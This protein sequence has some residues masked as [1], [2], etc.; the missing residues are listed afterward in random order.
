MINENDSN[1][2]LYM[3][4]ETI[5][6]K[7]SDDA[8]NLRLKFGNIKHFNQYHFEYLDNPIIFK[9]NQCVRLKNM[10]HAIK[11]LNIQ[12][13]DSE[14]LSKIIRRLHAGMRVRKNDTILTRSNAVFL[15]YGGESL[16]PSCLDGKEFLIEIEIE[17]YKT[18]DSGFPTPIWSLVIAHQSCDFL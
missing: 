8:N 18:N 3:P 17:G 11:V 12:N 13:E 16:D 2:K 15:G 5:N 1:E 7:H 4:N 6:F 14:V 10:K 9:F